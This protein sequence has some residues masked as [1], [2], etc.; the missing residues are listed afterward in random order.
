VGWCWTESCSP[1]LTAVSAEAR[2]LTQGRE[3]LG[4][5]LVLGLCIVVG[6]KKCPMW[7]EWRALTVIFLSFALERLSV[8]C[9]LRYNG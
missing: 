3:S 4:V 2:G 5:P 6:S 9:N 8:P 7:V 1:V